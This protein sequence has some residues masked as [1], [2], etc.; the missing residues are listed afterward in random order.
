MTRDMSTEAA[1]IGRVWSTPGMPTP[2]AVAWFE[3]LRSLSTEGRRKYVAGLRAYIA[4][5]QQDAGIERM[6]VLVDLVEQMNE[7]GGFP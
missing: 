5:H 6:E 3:D 1:I 7:G 2:E 4:D